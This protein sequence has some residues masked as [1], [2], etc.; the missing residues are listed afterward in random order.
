MRHFS[1]IL[2]FT[3]FL[4]VTVARAEYVNIWDVAGQKFIS[5][6]ILLKKLETK[7]IILLGARLDNPAHNQLAAHILKNLARAG[8]K[9]HILL[10]HVERNKQNAFAIYLQRHPDPSKEFDASGLDMLLD[11]SH[12]GQPGWSI[13]RPV[14]DMAMLKK[15]PL[16]AVNFSRYEVGQ[17]HR[18]DLGGLPGDVRPD[19]LPLLLSPLP[20]M[21]KTRLIEE[22]EKVYCGNLPP[23]SLEKLT[24]IHRARNGLF[25]LNITQ[26]TSEPGD[27]TAVL[28][29]PQKHILK[30]SGVP[31]WLDRM[32]GQKQVISLAFV[33][34]GQS[35]P[36]FQKIKAQ[37][38]KES[39]DFIWF[40]AKLSRPDPCGL[41]KP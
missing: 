27:R 1:F 41:L 32:G 9:P 17:L 38:L 8:R 24:L 40:T 7:K 39:V 28:I 29:A 10:G 11:W 12:S 25:A 23:E 4:A 30:N 37:K 34:A 36:S 21:I 19:L 14:F 5:E 35:K 16:K 31:R 2:F 20:K 15:L 33:E 26:L 18:E 3:L 22:I 6:N 13:V